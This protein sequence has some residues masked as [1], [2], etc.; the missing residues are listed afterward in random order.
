MSYKALYRTYRPSTFEEVAGQ[1]HIV[2][3]L[4]NAL[5]SGK[6][7]HAYLFTG[8]RGTGKT[9]MAKLFAKALNC[10]DGV[11]H[12]CD[13]CKN[14]LAINEGSHPDVIEIDAASN[15]GVEE[16]RD[17]I[18]KVKYSTILGRNKVYIIDE[19]HMMTPGA[20]NAL[21]KTLEEPPQNVIF[22]L[23]TTEPHKILPTILSR[24]QRYDF[25]KLGDIDIKERMRLVLEKE[26]VPFDE[27]AVNLIVSLSD[28]GMRDALS[29]L[30]QVLA[31]SQNK[32]VAGDILSIFSLESKQEKVELLKLISTGKTGNVLEKIKH[33]IERGTDI[34]RLTSDILLILKD[35]LIYKTTQ[36]FEY[37]EMIDESQAQDLSKL[38][39]VKTCKAFIDLVMEA[40][41]DFKNV[42]SIN[43]LFEITILKM[44]SIGN[45]NTKE[46]IKRTEF[47]KPGIKK[48]EKIEETL[49]EEEF[50]EEI[51]N[52]ELVEEKPIV[53]EIT[54]ENPTPQASLFD[55][56]YDERDIDPSLLI[57]EKISVKDGMYFF[58]DEQI[59]EVMTVAKKDIKKQMLSSWNKISSLSLHPELGAKAALLSDAHPLVAT[60]QILIIEEDLPSKATKVNLK[61]A[62]KD[63]Q[64]VIQLVF[65]KKMFVYALTRSESV[66]LQQKFINLKQVGKLARP[67]T[68]EIKFMEK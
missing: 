37:L 22:I 64:K 55:F 1:Q 44:T 10:D 29:I 61:E 60:K 14:C 39:D 3:T 4:K 30:D 49:A 35:V 51:K 17:L 58:T 53:K 38:I 57:P 59:I 41:K 42:P 40:Q 36:S 28:G 65:K 21:L 26:N 47:K 12:Q 48:V 54:K 33:Y 11:G 31:Y 27:E 8:P 24:C 16:A 66:T 7:A 13:H 15:N 52:P 25:S 32:L 67:D 20:F 6:I 18:D 43:P 2:K 46:E 5:E 50:F 23:A 19:V 63:L 68:I 56:T 62:Q 34:K 9:T 45:E